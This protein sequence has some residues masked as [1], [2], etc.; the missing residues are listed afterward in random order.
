MSS[1]RRPGS[2]P[3]SLDSVLQRNDREDKEI[4]PRADTRGW[5]LN[6]FLDSLIASQLLS[7]AE[8]MAVIIA[9]NP[10]VIAIPERLV[11]IKWASHVIPANTANSNDILKNGSFIFHLLF[12]LLS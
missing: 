11:F 9:T 10:D 5:A 4:A 1:R 2:I 8:T 6:Y 12:Y 3:D 7:V